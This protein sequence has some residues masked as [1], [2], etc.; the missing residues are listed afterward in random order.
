MR[1]HGIDYSQTGSTNENKLAF[2]YGE[3]YVLGIVLCNKRINK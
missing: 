3:V 1:V 2:I